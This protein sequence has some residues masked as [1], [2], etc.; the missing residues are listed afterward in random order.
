MLFCGALPLAP[1][2]EGSFKGVVYPPVLFGDS[3]TLGLDLPAL[4]LCSELGLSGA[5]QVAILHDFGRIRLSSSAL[6]CFR[7]LFGLFPL[8]TQSGGLVTPLLLGRGA[9]GLLAT[10]PFK[11]APL[12]LLFRLP[13]SSSRDFNLVRGEGPGHEQNFVLALLETQ[14]IPRRIASREV[15]AQPQQSGANRKPPHA[16]GKICK[17]P[18]FKRCARDK[19]YEVLNE[20]LVFLVRRFVRRVEHLS[21]CRAE[22]PCTATVCP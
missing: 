10:L 15:F 18:P 1:A 21:W 7:T 5:L 14:I 2:I 6:S 19:N 12:E 9:R 4:G 16:L 3:R 17:H 13:E 20:R 22:L 11:L 8:A